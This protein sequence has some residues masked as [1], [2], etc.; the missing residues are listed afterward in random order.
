MS[1]TEPNVMGNLEDI[2]RDLGAWVTYNRESN[3]ETLSYRDANSHIAAVQTPDYR[4]VQYHVNEE[5]VQMYLTQ[6]QQID[7]PLARRIHQELQSRHSTLE[8]TE[9]QGKT[10]IG[11]YFPVDEFTDLPAIMIIHKES[12]H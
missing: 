10:M 6:L 1:K 9:F 8:Q 2:A 12:K 11:N 4:G 5:K 3:I 7:N